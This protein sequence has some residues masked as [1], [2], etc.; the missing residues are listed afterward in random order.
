MQIIVPRPEG[1]VSVSVPVQ[2]PGSGTGTGTGTDEPPGEIQSLAISTALGYPTSGVSINNAQGG[3]QDMEDIDI[4]WSGLAGVNQAFYLAAFFFSLVFVWQLV[5]SMVG[6]GGHDTAGAGDVDVDGTSG[7]M[8]A[9]GDG[10]LDAH[11][12][13]HAAESA[14]AFKLFSL[15]AILAFC[16]MFT[17]SAA[18]NL[19][20]GTNLGPA[21]AYSV[22]WGLAGWAVVVVL[23]NSLRR[24]AETG[25]QRI[26]TSIGQEGTVYLDIPKDGMGQVRVKVSGV[27]GVVKARSLGGMPLKAG[28]PISVVRVVEAGVLEV[29]EMTGSKGSNPV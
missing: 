6:I 16:T 9:S 7:H 2:R 4:W 21:L 26:E 22:L 13:D 17:W 15:G 24:L 20:S 12:A 25:N 1:P 28:T 19:N 29:V 3:A 23:I 27:V 10:S 18:L 11:A 8:D 14:T 5:A